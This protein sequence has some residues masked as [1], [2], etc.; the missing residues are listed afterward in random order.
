MSLEDNQSQKP[1]DE[2]N[3][4]IRFGVF[5]WIILIFAMI[6]LPCSV[7]LIIE[8]GFVLLFTSGLENFSQFLAGVI[9]GVLSGWALKLKLKKFKRTKSLQLYKFIIVATWIIAALILIPA[10]FSIFIA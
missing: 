10:I 4:I 9:L 6:I 3:K 8:D 5:D 7:I 1:E 2:T